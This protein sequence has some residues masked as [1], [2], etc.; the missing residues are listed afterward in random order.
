[1][2]A[3]IIQKH[4]DKGL[5]ILQNDVCEPALIVVS[6]PFD[7]GDFHAVGSERSGVSMEGAFTFQMSPY[8]QT[9]ID[10]VRTLLSL[11]GDVQI[12]IRAKGEDTEDGEDITIATKHCICRW[13]DDSRRVK[14]TFAALG[15]NV[16]V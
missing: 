14:I 9:H 13:E 11:P 15:G 2:D 5:L 3:L 6:I 16:L 10:N 1:M 4:F 8:S 7:E 12:N